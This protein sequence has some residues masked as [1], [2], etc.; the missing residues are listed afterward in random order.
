MIPVA[1]LASRKTLPGAERSLS[2]GLLHDGELAALGPA[3]AAIGRGLIALSWDDEAVDWSRFEAAIVRTTWDYA[4][5]PAEFFAAVDRIAATVPLFNPPAILRWNADKAYL[6]DLAAR[7]AP[8]IPTLWVDHADV[9]AYEAAFAR[10]DCERLV[11][12]PRIGAGAWRQAIVARGAPPPEAEAVPPGAAM[13][14]PF[15]SSIVTEGE[16]SFV[17]CGGELSHAFVKRPAP[18]DYRVQPS[19]GGR[20]FAIEPAQADLALA[21]AALAAAALAPLLYARVD[22]A[23]LP[24]G[25]LAVMELEAVE[26]HLYPA[27]GPLLGANLARAYRRLIG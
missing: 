12:K 19:Y 8:S 9:A 17:F 11:V 23:R 4:Q 2:H 15:L 16:Y 24:D 22:M 18:G 13:I 20:E 10:F 27:V 14:Q 21:E 25:R 1:F 5:R 7:G 26:P 6:R 3:F